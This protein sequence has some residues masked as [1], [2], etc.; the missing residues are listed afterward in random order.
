MVHM[1]LSISISD[2]LPD[3]DFLRVASIIFS[4]KVHKNLRIEIPSISHLTYQI[5]PNFIMCLIIQFL[6]SLNDH[7]HY[8]KFDSI[9]LCSHGNQ[10][11]ESQV[12]LVELKC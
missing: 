5:T 10:I 4:T 12:N 7:V 9:M 11:F 3:Y 8:M 1:I 2:Q 6:R